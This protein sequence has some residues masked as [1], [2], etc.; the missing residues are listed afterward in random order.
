MLFNGFI[1]LEALVTPA[2]IS[3]G[4]KLRTESPPP[5]YE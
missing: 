1:L 2:D 3:M 5:Y 4:I